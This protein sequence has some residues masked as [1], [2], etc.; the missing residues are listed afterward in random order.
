MGVRE[1]FPLVIG[2]GESRPPGIQRVTIASC[3]VHGE[4]LGGIDWQGG[5]LAAL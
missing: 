4:S 5:A 3:C 1:Q 2:A